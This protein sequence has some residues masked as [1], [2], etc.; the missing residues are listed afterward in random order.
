MDGAVVQVVRAGSFFTQNLRAD[1]TGR[2][3]VLS[4]RQGSAE[5]RPSAIME[6]VQC[7]PRAR[8]RSKPFPR[9]KTIMSPP[10]LIPF[11][12][13]PFPF[14]SPSHPSSPHRQHPHPHNQ[15]NP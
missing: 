12:P 8:Q 1:W 11:H 13:F 5:K 15:H 4:D 14:L 7:T 2:A 6:L 3:N 10:S 9:N